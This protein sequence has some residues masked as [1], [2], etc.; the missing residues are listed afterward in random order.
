MRFC[1]TCLLIGALGLVAVVYAVTR[2]RPGG[3]GSEEGEQPAMSGTSTP[4]TVSARKTD[5][6]WKEILTPEQYQITRRKGT[7]RAFS[8]AYYHCKKEGV[9]RCVCC[10][11]PLFSSRAK[12]D[13][14]SGWPS[15]WKPAEGGGVKTAPDDTHFTRR[16][17][18]L[19]SRCDAHLGHLFE[20]GPQPTG[21]R[22]C[23]N[24]AA[25]RLDESP[26]KPSRAK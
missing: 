13:S 8:G 15:F 26:A 9:Y 18:V 20:D 4:G 22:Y 6:Q 5:A 11:A 23:V 25:L 17:E 3:P 16:V 10:G 2:G 7:E 1:S 24:S 19:C 14:G 21:L 12:Y